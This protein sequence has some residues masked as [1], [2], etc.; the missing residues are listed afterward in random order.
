ML[1]K[2]YC[3]SAYP[4][5]IWNVLLI[6]AELL[7]SLEELADAVHPDEEPLVDVQRLPRV[8]LIH[9]E[10]LLCNENTHLLKW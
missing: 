10:I 4:G 5:Q 7:G 2:Q 8:L 3:N 1:S 6:D 9:V